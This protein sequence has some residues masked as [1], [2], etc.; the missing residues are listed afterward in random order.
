M[1]FTVHC[2]Y[3]LFAFL[4]LDLDGRIARFLKKISTR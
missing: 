3:L 2:A 4:V 1:R